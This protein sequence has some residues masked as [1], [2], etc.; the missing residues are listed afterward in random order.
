MDFIYGRAIYQNKVRG[1]FASLKRR[2]RDKRGAVL[3]ELGITIFLMD[4]LLMRMI[5]FFDHGGKAN[6]VDTYERV[7]YNTLIVYETFVTSRFPF[8]VV[9]LCV[10]QKAIKNASGI[11]ALFHL[12]SKTPDNDIKELVTG[13]LWNLSSQPVR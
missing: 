10:Q 1:A 12:L 5:K 4:R 2:M 3:G 9:N 6:S 7:K 8:N 11:P 13:I